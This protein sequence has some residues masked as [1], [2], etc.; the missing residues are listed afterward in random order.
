MG[1][2]ERGQLNCWTFVAAESNLILVQIR[3][4]IAYFESPVLTHVIDIT[5]CLHIYIYIFDLFVAL[6]R[7]CDRSWMYMI[8]CVI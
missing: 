7:D 2:A 8:C 3:F 4:G 6:V 1:P 5:F